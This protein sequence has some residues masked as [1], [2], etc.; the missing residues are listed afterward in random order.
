MA[1]VVWGLYKE[2]SVQ[3]SSSC[4]LVRVNIQPFTLNYY[5]FFAYLEY[6]L[7]KENKINCEAKFN[8]RGF[9]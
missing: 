2:T 7:R 6:S 5:S 9:I 3:K 1:P 4:N 8:L